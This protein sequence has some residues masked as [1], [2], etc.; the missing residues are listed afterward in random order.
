MR[1]MA[2]G[3]EHATYAAIPQ[4]GEIRRTD[5]PYSEDQHSEMS[6]RKS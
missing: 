2:R 1:V 3:T 4:C 5:R 6:V